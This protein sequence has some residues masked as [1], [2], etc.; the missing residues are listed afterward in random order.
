LAEESKGKR[1]N[2]I[3]R[4][5]LEDRLKELEEEIAR[6]E[7][8]IARCETALLT[9]VSAQE[10]Q[11]K[12]HELAALRADVADRM[13]EWEQVSQALEPADSADAK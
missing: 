1:L 3:K 10:T 6:S 2:P 8:A 13:T 11:K 12:T 9:F 4:K 7:S 5:Q